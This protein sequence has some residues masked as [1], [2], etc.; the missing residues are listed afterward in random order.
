[1]GMVNITISLYRVLANSTIPE[2]WWKIDQAK[3]GVW[4]SGGIQFF[5]VSAE[6]PTGIAA[7]FAASGLIGLCKDKDNFFFWFFLFFSL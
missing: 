4:P 1:M 6:V 2:R 7:T 3:D 5:T